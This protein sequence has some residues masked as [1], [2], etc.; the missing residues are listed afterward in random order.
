MASTTKEK[1]ITT[2][3]TSLW[4]PYFYAQNDIC[5]N[6]VRI[7]CLINGETLSRII[8]RGVS[9]T[10]HESLD[11]WTT[12][13]YTA[14]SVA[15]SYSSKK[16]RGERERRSREKVYKM[17]M[18]FPPPLLCCRACMHAGM[19]ASI[20]SRAHAIFPMCLRRNT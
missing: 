1:S 15:R 9:I 7:G 19:H 13:L 5:Q 8:H 10:H 11:Y 12:L 18:P 16:N 3:V 6:K 2:V 4:A 17:M 14:S 20:L